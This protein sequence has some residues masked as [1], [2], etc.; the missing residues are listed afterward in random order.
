MAA[1]REIVLG[2]LFGGILAASARALAAMLQRAQGLQ[3]GMGL[4]PLF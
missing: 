4:A 3:S 2:V 1:G